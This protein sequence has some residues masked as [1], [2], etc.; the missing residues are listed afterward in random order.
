[1]LEKTIAFIKRFL[2][3]QFIRFILVAMLN[4]AFGWCVYA[5]LVFLFKTLQVNNPYIPASLI[6]T[7]ISI[8]FNFKTYGILVFKNKSNR[9]IFRFL[10]V[11]T[12]TYYC[13]I[14]G[15]A[16]LEYVNINNYIAGALTAIPVGF[17]GYFLNKLFVF[18][19]KPC[20]FV[21]VMV[22]LIFAWCVYALLLRLFYH[23]LGPKAFILSALMDML[24][25]FFFNFRAYQQVFTENRKRNIVATILVFSAIFLIF[26]GGV[27]VLEGCAFMQHVPSKLILEHWVLDFYFSG[28][29]LIIP[30]G[31]MGYFLNK[32]FIFQSN[33]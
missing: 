25:I 7:I 11:Y 26:V 18:Q 24:I 12:I 20:A 16:L 5:S 21:V 33:R 29:M 8:L 10:V 31:M 13:N 28:A 14:T 32:Y 4:T 3:P 19:E 23:V 9:L 6:G 2:T 27:A 1:M 17:L 30:V 22:N 15:I